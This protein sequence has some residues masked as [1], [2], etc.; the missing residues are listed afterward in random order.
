M[1]GF[2]FAE[3]LQPIFLRH[4]SLCGRAAIR[5]SRARRHEASLMA[6]SQNS[7][8]KLGVANGDKQPGKVTFRLQATEG[9]RVMTLS[10]KG[11]KNKKRNSKNPR[12]PKRTM[13]A[14]AV[15]ACSLQ[16]AM[17]EETAES[18]EPKPIGAFPSSKCNE[19]GPPNEPDRE[20]VMKQGEVLTS[21]LP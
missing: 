7:E 16:A 6:R 1:S 10:K 11:T 5:K 2:C 13:T 21:L 20:R 3:T 9:A 8:R 19:R 15:L 14:D 12:G 17:A 4:R 18:A